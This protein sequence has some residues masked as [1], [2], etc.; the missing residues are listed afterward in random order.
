IDR[1]LALS[2]DAVAGAG[3]RLHAT[4]FFQPSIR[5]TRTL[6][7]PRPSSSSFFLLFALRLQCLTDKKK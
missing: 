5:K 7:D 2:C 6:L 4:E 1:S 3:F